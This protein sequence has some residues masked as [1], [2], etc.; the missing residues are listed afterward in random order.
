MDA[1]KRGPADDL[2]RTVSQQGPVGRAGVYNL[3]CGVRLGH[4]V[5]HVFRDVSVSVFA[6]AQRILHPL[7]FRDVDEESL[8]MQ[9]SPLVVPN[10][11]GALGCPEDGPVPA[12]DMALVIQDFSVL[13]E[14]ECRPVPDLRVGIDLGS[15]VRHG[16]HQLLRR[17]VAKHPGQGRI[18][19]E[20]PAV[21]R[22]GEESDG[23][24]A[25]EIPVVAVCLP[26][27]LGS[28]LFLWHGEL[29]AQRRLICFA[30]GPR[31]AREA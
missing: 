8:E 3:P 25:E 10:G 18:R 20:K 2:L 13:R 26:G 16:V 5:R 21:R 14:E 29:L 24:A 1:I 11:P 17:L 30:N 12:G 6:L 7:A 23:G 4:D 15:D 31:E 27:W 28:L 9:D 22:G 19:V